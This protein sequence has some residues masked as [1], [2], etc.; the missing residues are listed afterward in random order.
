MA[1]SC[2]LPVN[3]LLSPLSVSRLA[4]EIRQLITTS[5][6]GRVKVEARLLDNSVVL[7]DIGRSQYAFL[8]LKVIRTVPRL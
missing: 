2:G 1:L 7:I 8:R 3:I 4:V 6:E 5:G